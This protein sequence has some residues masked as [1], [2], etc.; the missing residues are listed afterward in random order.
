MRQSLLNIPC[1]V[2]V[3]WLD[4][5]RTFTKSSARRSRSKT[6]HE[7]DLL[8]LFSAFLTGRLYSLILIRLHLGCPSYRSQ[9]RFVQELAMQLRQQVEQMFR[10]PR[11]QAA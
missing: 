8:P 10:L 9:L 3:L 2:I 6:S 5:H 4:I 7:D 1:R 11:Y